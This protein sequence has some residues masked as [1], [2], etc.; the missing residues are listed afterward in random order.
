M[1][2]HRNPGMTETEI[3]SRIRDALHVSDILWLT[4][5]AIIG[6]DTDGHIDQLARFTT[7]N[8][9]LYAWSE[10]RHDPQ[11]AG[12]Q[13]NL[14][15]LRTGLARLNRRDELIALPI[16]GPVYLF[17]NRIPACYCNF[18]LTNQSILVP[19]FGD[20]N[21][22]RARAIIAE[23]FPERIAIS[24]PSANLTVGLGSFHCLTQQQPKTTSRP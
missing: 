16:P 10:D 24:L 1:D 14:E 9:I 18:Y 13:Q 22:E 7:S 8:S 3:Q 12:L 19:A 6:D 2:E 20:P 21:D 11:Q 15:D 4:G 17:G 5:D 23:Q